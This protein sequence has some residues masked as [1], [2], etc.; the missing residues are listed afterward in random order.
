MHRI[1]GYPTNQ[2]PTSR[3][4]RQKAQSGMYKRRHTDSA[5][6]Y[7]ESDKMAARGVAV[8]SQNESTAIAESRKG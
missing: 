3:V 8:S 1:Q 7:G 2:N 4:N 5:V 6:A